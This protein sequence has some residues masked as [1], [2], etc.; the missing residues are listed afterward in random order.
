MQNIY[1]QIRG[2]QMNYWIIV[3]EVVFTTEFAIR[4]SAR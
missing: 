4:S 3:F 2:Y 1:L